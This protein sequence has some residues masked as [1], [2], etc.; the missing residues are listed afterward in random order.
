MIGNDIIDL[1]LAKTASNW[2]RKGFLEKQF[3]A[4]EQQLI[5]EAPN[6]FVMVWRLWSMKE[7]AY[8]IFTQQH[9]VRFFAPKKFEC[10]LRSAKE[11]VVCFKGQKFYTSSLINQHYIFTKASLEKE[12]SSY[13]EM[14]PPHEIDNMIK[15]KL[16]E[17]TAL[18]V[19]R[20]EQK[21][22][23]NGVPSYYNKTTLLTSSCSISH[24]GKYGAYSFV[25]A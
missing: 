18:S 8:K 19:S 13:S 10:K 11:G 25:K 22:S 15:K 24:H 1:S 23:K 7:A 9:S 20:I 17:L 3:T 6:S 2:Q 4:N 5:L 21:K 14:V 16:K 12:I